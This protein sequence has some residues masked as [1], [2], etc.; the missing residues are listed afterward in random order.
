M[1]EVD[2][3]M[4]LFNLPDNSRELYDKKISI[5]RFTEETANEYESLKYEHDSVF[6]FQNHARDDSVY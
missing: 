5:K 1:N 2:D 3:K 4:V 6:E